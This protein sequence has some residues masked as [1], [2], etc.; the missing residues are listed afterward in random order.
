LDD[1]AGTESPQAMTDQINKSK[2][3]HD[4]EGSERSRQIK[5]LATLVIDMYKVQKSTNPIAVI[6]SKEDNGIK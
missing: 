3:S 2:L 1:K 5:Q 4:D 6:T